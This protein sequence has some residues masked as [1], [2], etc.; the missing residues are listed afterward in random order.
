MLKNIPLTESLMSLISIAIGILGANMTGYYKPN[1]S[2]DFV[3]NTIAGVFGSILIIK[4]LGRLGFDPVSIMESGSTNWSLVL[5]NLIVSFVAGGASIFI[6]NKIQK[7]L[8]SKEELFAH[9]I[10]SF[11]VV[12]F[13]EG[14]SYILLMLVAVPW[15]YMVGDA[16]LVKLLGMP[17]GILFVLYVILALLIRAKMKWD[18]KST[19]IVLIASLLP[20]GTFYIDRKYFS[21]K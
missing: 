7:K 5:L 18:I 11:R 21:E 8:K 16:H 13:L 1:V 14:V 3:G 6:L 12:S 4:F 10:S 2:Y 15:K 20:F 9:L 19:F 17:H